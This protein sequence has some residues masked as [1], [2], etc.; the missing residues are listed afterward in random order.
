M[1]APLVTVALTCFNAKQT[2]ARAISSA[3]A[4][5]WPNLEVLVVD[6]C[7]SDGSVG[8]I[9]A[10]IQGAGNAHLIR[11]HVNRGAAAAR[12]TL[13]REARGE[14]IVFFDDDDESLPQRVA[15]QVGAIVDYEKRS[16]CELIFCYASGIRRYPNGYQLDLPAIGSRGKVLPHGEAVADYLL[17]YH[18][19]AGWF[20]GA[21]VPSCALMARKSSYLE[22]GGFDEELKRVEDADLAIRAALKGAHFLGTK[23]RLFI[24]YATDALD[25]SP[26]RN[27]ESEQRLAR[28]NRD[29]LRG[30][31]RYYYALH[32]PKLRYWH[33]KRRYARFALE[34]WGLF[35]HNPLAVLGHILATGPRRLMHEH[36]MRKEGKR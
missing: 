12:N 33:F 28:K 2:I 27:L 19:Q 13:L 9:E 23:E 32:W 10:M 17:Y 26:E 35:L 21:G 6:D 36:R 30:K 29:Y 18:R 15:V 20:Y 8:V 31:R 16:G 3:L 7:S 1:E 34:F 25:K 22:V 4:Q 5:R 11:H 24:Q 14:F